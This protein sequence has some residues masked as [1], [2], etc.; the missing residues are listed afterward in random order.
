MYKKL[1]FV[2]VG[3]GISVDLEPWGGK[4]VHRLVGMIREPAMVGNQG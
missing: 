4:G 1:G 3:E 2:Q